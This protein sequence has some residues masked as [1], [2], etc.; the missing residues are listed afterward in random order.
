MAAGV[1]HIPWYA[2]VFR[3]DELAA[4]LEEV[5]PIARHYGATSWSVQRSTDDAYQFRHMISFDNKAD[6]DL[7]WNGTEMQ[8]F[9]AH[10]SGAFQAPITYTWF[11]VVTEEL[12]AAPVSA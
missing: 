8:R 7:F 10:N 11:A 6:W 5:A 2:T 4:A 3:G 1:A 9:R 12:G